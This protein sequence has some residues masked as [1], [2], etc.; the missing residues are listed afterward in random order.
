[1]NQ[2]Y[3]AGTG[4]ILL[5]NVYCTGGETSLADCRHSAWGQ[6]DCGHSE[7]VFVICVNSFSITGNK[8]QFYYLVEFS[9]QFSSSFQHMLHSIDW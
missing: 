8:L 1:M 7:D 2:P 5:D 6:H 4:P 9:G 3:G